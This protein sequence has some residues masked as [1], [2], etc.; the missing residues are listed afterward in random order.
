MLPVR[1]VPLV[2]AL[3]AVFTPL[4]RAQSTV[5]AEAAAA[6][7]EAEAAL[8]RIFAEALARGQAYAHLRELVGR[9]PGRLSGSSALAAAIDWA[10][11]TLRRVGVDTLERQEVMVPHWWCRTGSAARR[12]ARACCRV[13]RRNRWPSSRSVARWRRR[14]PA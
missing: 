1:F 9:H 14:R 4:A 6:S 3:A 8:Q 13:T 2:A 10:E 11:G 5:P 12:S 7:T